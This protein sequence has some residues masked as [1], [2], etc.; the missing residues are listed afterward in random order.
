MTL[1]LSTL[2]Y[3]APPGDDDLGSPRADS[4]RRDKEEASR[5]LWSAADA[6]L[7]ARIHD[8]SDE[9]A[10]A[11]FTEMYREHLPGLISLGERY[12]GS[13]ALAEDV[14]AD[15]F[16]TIWRRRESWTPQYGI[17][18]YL[19]RVVRTRALDQLRNAA[20]T[21][22]IGEVATAAGDVPGVSLERSLDE[23]LDEERLLAEVAAAIA[24]FPAVRR[25]VMELRWQHGFPIEEIATIL[26]LKRATVDQHLSRGLRA[27][28]RLLPKM[29]GE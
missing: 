5:P 2:W 1:P 21:R 27:L 3:V 10:R 25:Q 24:T 23:S 4:P 14:V 15:M 6:A 18:A 8:S 9:I 7:L 17:R 12:L 16:I 28:R 19:Y 22:R 11:A 13:Q 29:L 20:T 26:S